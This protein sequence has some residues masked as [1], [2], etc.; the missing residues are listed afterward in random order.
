MN[1]PSFNLRDLYG[2]PSPTG[3]GE[4]TKDNQSIWVQYTPPRYFVNIYRHVSKRRRRRL[5]GKKLKLT[6]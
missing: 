5:R 4:D 2:T 1:S 6:F 3:D